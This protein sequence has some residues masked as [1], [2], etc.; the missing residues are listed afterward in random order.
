MRQSI[1]DEN[2]TDPVAGIQGNL[3]SVRTMITISNIM[4]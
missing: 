3:S 2:T 4:K 1:K